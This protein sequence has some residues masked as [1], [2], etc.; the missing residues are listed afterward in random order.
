MKNRPNI[1]LIMTD[2]QRFDSLGCYGAGAIPTPNLDRL[3]SEGVVFENCYVNNP[4]CTPSRASIFTGKPLPGHGVY[5]LNDCLPDREVLFT[6]RL[7]TAGYQ[8]AL[9]GKLHVSGALFERNRRN[10]GDGFDVYDWCHEPALFLDGKYNSYGKWLKE[11]H[12]DFHRQLTNQGRRLKNVPREKHATRW[13]ADRTIELIRKRDVDKPFCFV[14]SIFD[15]HNPYTDYPAEMREFVDPEKIGE[16]SPGTED[17]H[18]GEPLGIAREREHG[19]MGN[20][21]DYPDSDIREM[22]IGYFASVCLI[23][24]EVGRVLDELAKQGLRDTT[25]VIFVSDHG[26]MLGDHEL[27]AKGAFFYDACV[28]VPFIIRHPGKMPAG[29]RW[30][31]PVQP[32]DIAATVLAGA[33]FSAREIAEYM[34]ESMDLTATVNGDKTVARDYAVCV[35]RG[36]GISGEKKYFEPPIHA[37]MIRDERF[38]LNA[39]HEPATAGIEM[40]GELYDMIN[41]PEERKNLWRNPEYVSDKIRLMGKLLNWLVVEDLQTNG[42]RS[43]ES[44]AVP[45]E[46]LCS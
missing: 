29:K 11:K 40:E 15:P 9:V 27:L 16:V 36:S 20:F 44:A 25:M 24:Q 17:A 10:R 26:D 6:K 28:K 43:G 1:L 2:Q 39:Y 38:K 21:H 23:D 41:D 42:I 7:N 45:A 19:Y 35:Y 22:R 46:S 13:S 31:L 37:T 33:E 8:T 34:P 4:V 14:M 32:H 5:R 3:A 12:P 30:R 18:L